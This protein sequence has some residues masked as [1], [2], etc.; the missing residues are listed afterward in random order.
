MKKIDL[1]GRRF[2]SLTVRGEAEGRGGKARWHCDCECGGSTITCS[3]NLTGGRALSCGCLQRRRLAASKTTHG[4]AKSPEHRA[5]QAMKTR[6]YNP[7]YPLFH[8]YGG[9]GI[10]VCAAWRESFD[11]FLADVG[12]RPSPTHSLD[13]I[14]N[15]GGYEPTNCRW[16]DK[17]T[18]ARNSSFARTVTF[19]GEEVSIAEAAERSG[20]PAPLLY[21]R[22]YQ[23]R[24]GDELFAPVRQRRRIG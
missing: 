21:T 17:A 24:S 13:R 6:C 1:V 4:K 22:R 18:Q 2:G 5:W 14:D 3:S 8:R 7:N 16:A 12:P 19:E 10:F 23:G 15:D 20:I 9:R 11:A